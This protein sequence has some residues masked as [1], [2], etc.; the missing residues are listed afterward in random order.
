MGPDGPGP[1]PSPSRDASLTVGLSAPSAS[2]TRLSGAVGSLEG[3]DAIQRDLD[4]LQKWAHVNLM[5]FNK[6][7]CKVLHLSENNHLYQYRLGDEW[8]ESSPAEKD[9]RVL[10]DE[11]FNM[12]HQCALAAQKANCILGCITRNMTSRLREVI[13]PLYSAVKRPHLEYCVQLWSPQYKKDMDL[14]E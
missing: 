7:K 6:A 14:L 9:L 10:V 8:I 3:K 12:R 1:L 11:K 2:D 5:N 4:R 13:P